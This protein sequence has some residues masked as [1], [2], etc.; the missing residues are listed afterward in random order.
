MLS[1]FLDLPCTYLYVVE[2]ILSLIWKCIKKTK[3]QF[4]MT[5]LVV[6]ATMMMPLQFYVI[7]TMITTLYDQKIW[8]TI[9][10]CL[11]VPILI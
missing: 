10:L 4:V 2:L 7:Y 3:T 8:L 1:T 6:C 11:L 9:T 5:N